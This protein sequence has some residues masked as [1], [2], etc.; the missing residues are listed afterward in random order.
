VNKAFLKNIRRCAWTLILKT[1]TG[2]CKVNMIGDL[3]GVGTVW[4][5][6]EGTANI[7]S[8]HRM[9]VNS[10]WSV[11]YSTD[12]YRKTLLH[13]NLSYRCITS[14]GIRVEFIPTKQGLYVMDCSQYFNNHEQDVY[15]FGK[16]NKDNGTD[17]GAAMCHNLDGH[18]SPI[19]TIEKSKRRFTKRD[20]IK[21]SMVRRFQHVAGHPSDSTL[22]YAAATNS[23][24]NSPITRRDVQLAADMLGKS[25][26]AVRGKT[27]RTQP[28][29][30][31]ELV[32]E[33]PM[34]IMEYYKDVE[35]SIDVMHVNKVP[36][37]VTISKNIHYG[38]V[39]AL[40][41][42]KIPTLERTISAVFK[43]Y[44]VRG[45]N[46]TNV[47]VD[48]QFKAIRDRKIIAANINVVSRG[49]HVPSIERFIRVMKERARC[50]YAMLP[51]TRLP[52]MVIIH[53]LKTVVFYINAF[54]WR[55][56]V[57][58]FLSPATIVEGVMLDFN[59]HFHLIFGEYVHTYEGTTN[60]MKDRTV[61]AIALGPSGNIQGGVRCYSLL[62]GKVLHR[63]MADITVMKMP[64]E[65]IR[66]LTYRAR[67]QKARD[68]L[69]FADRHG[70]VDRDHSMIEQLEQPVDVN[71]EDQ[72]HDIAVHM[73]HAEDDVVEHGNDV[74][75]TENE[76]NSEEDNEVEEVTGVAP[77]DRNDEVDAP[78][79]DLDSHDS[80]ED[81]YATP[82]EDSDSSD[83][84]EEDHTT[85]RSGRVSK[86][87]DF[88]RNFPDIY[89]ETHLLSQSD[90][91][92][93]RPYY[94]DEDQQL[95][96]SEGVF[97]SESFYSQDINV[98]DRRT[99]YNS[100]IKSLND[101]EY[102]L[103]TEALKWY[104]FSP[105]EVEAMAYKVSTMS[106]KQGLQRHGK[107]AKES[108]MKEIK[109]LVGNDCF[110][111]TKYEELSQEMKDKALPIL[112]F[113]VL[114]R[115]GLLKTRGV[116]DGSVQR[117]Y[118]SKDDVSSPTPDFYA[119]KYICA[120]IAKEARDVASV[121]LPG[122]FL[123]TEQEGDD[124]ILLKLTG[125]VALLLVECEP[126]KWRKHL[127]K[128]N[129]RWVI[130]VVCKKAI[131]GT[132]NA[133]LLAYKKLAKLFKA[134]GMTMNP[135]DPCVWN[136]DIEGTQFTVV[137]H[138]DDLLMSHKSAEIVTMMIK[139][140]DTEYGTRD[141]LTVTRG[142]IHEYLGMTI[143][144]TVKGECAFSQY[145]FLKKLIE[146]VPDTLDVRYRNTPAPE[147]LFKVSE[148]SGLLDNERKDV[149]HMLT[150]KCL[151]ASQRSRP[152]IQLA[153]GFHCTR[154][155]EPRD[156]DWYKLGHLFGYIRKTRYMPLIIAMTD[157][158]TIIYIDG[159]HAIHTDARGHS[160]LFVTQ[161]KGAM[162]S[163]SKKLGVVTT[164]STET[165]I[166][167]TGERLPKCT[168]FR[169][170][171]LAQGESDKEDILMQD[172]K[173][174]I[175]L[176]KNYPY[177]TR[178]G[179]KHI[180][181]RYFFAVDKVKNKEIKIMYCPTEKMIAD[182][183]SKP[184]Q[185]KLFIDLRNEMLGIK[186]EDF[187]I[188]KNRY[189]AVLKQYD[190]YDDAEKDIY[191]I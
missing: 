1:Q 44:T 101:T 151:W 171:R 138:V 13:K 145:D 46:V 22:I 49:E 23:V 128:E 144:F 148:E 160:G 38:T 102:Q 31:T 132:M 34:T 114:K 14:E 88:A 47:H 190:L 58:Q 188:Y 107:E 12:E 120:V 32:Q 67:K 129:G 65:A 110:G 130:Y 56:G 64:Q 40:D 153:T 75:D 181:V 41:D 187:S 48:I 173:S 121:D 176:Q 95:R 45:F 25:E 105:R 182:Y 69:E 61:G 168:W 91:K 141:E 62:T 30:V 35:L 59:K 156:H 15:I 100:K 150:A 57:S 125:E 26:Y 122:F 170:F 127:H 99:K 167:S 78:D 134:W 172:N 108:A 37:L 96:L 9:V 24:K 106:V 51:Y 116:A 84:E 123:Q 124:V 109:N 42:L 157:E 93:L 6:P 152:D 169:Y 63:L 86:P 77:E 111:E 72:M 155:K 175:I 186:E 94:Y 87:Y 174:A 189:I 7:L 21:A 55:S 81:G 83:S 113:M 143:D 68:G 89:H 16:K 18:E 43:A 103:F 133:A 118:T 117:L 82:N 177:S 185:G 11:N 71:A 142:P 146:D 161:G 178:K 154:V 119:F 165:E 149:Y 73:E 90:G 104:E 52:R 126:N 54:V 39:N 159:A 158:G 191:D 166:V 19:D 36:F 131:Y 29:A 180:H 76:A 80:D 147:Y 28:E 70:D 79:E 50:Y 137:F 140:L 10:G 53:L 17:E 184:L 60:S 8:A 2:E 4:Y 162:I 97:V 85:T 27:T 33:V 66:R 136:A 183:N 135:Y 98:T 139:R 179:S 20:Q 112:M 92:Q 3:P 74:I 163:V 115:N 5:Y 164:S